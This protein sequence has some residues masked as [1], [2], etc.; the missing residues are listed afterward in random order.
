MDTIFA[1]LGGQTQELS[2]VQIDVTPGH[3]TLDVICKVRCNERTGVEMEALTGVSVSALTIY[4]MC[5]ALSHD[6]KISDIQLEQKS[7]GKNDF[8]R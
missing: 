8:S 4:D 5:K 7:G 6:I 1:I 3:N 2:K